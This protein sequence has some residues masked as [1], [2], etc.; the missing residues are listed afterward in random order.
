M[1]ILK[2]LEQYAAITWNQFVPLALVCVAMTVI[3][4]GVDM[5]MG[6]FAGLQGKAVKSAGKLSGKI[7]EVLALVTVVYYCLREGYGQVRKRHFKLSDFFAAGI[8]TMIRVTR[9]IHPLAGFIVFCLSVFHGYLFL[10]VGNF[11]MGKEIVSGIVSLIG[12]LSLVITGWMVYGSAQA[13]QIRKAHRYF[14][15]LFVGL[16]LAHKVLSD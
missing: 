13:Q 9:L 10:F 4:I 1:E 8:R 11:G 14:G 7:A 16:F 15:W 12:L 2:R 3:L 5:Q 6:L